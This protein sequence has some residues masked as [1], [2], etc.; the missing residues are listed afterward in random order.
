MKQDTKHYSAEWLRYNEL[1]IEIKDHTSTRIYKFKVNIDNEME[2]AR[3]LSVL[4]KYGHDV[5]YLGKLIKGMKSSG[6]S[7]F[8]YPLGN[9]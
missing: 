8:K 3:A 9:K 1:K 5:E 7:W 4:E 6:D 2:V